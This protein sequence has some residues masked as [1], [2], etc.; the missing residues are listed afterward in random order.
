MSKELL[1]AIARNSIEQHF[2]TQKSVDKAF[3]LDK[4]ANLALQGACF[5]TLTLHHELRGCIGSIVPHRSLLDDLYANAHAA[6]FNDPRFPPLTQDEYEQVDVEVSLLTSPK[7]QEYGSIEELKAF[8]N[9]KHGVILKQGY[10]QATFLPQVWEQLPLFEDF[11][12]HLCNKA[13]LS[14]DCL[15]EHPEIYLYEVEIYKE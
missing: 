7:K 6:A 1:I 2:K 8:I 4:D 15:K 3:W 13:G 10:A 9:P 5:V 11:F 14:I 12:A